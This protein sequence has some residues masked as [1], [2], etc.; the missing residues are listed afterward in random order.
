M[1]IGRSI[2]KAVK[3]VTHVVTHPF[4]STKS[5]VSSLIGGGGGGSSAAEID[6]PDA[7]PEQGML[8]DEN[9]TENSET[10]ET[11]AKKRKRRGKSALKVDSTT[12][13]TGVNLGAK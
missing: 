7:A 6:I 5:A 11:I 1:G 9:Q 8:K 10:S 3:R 4:S 12:P 13:A 2:R